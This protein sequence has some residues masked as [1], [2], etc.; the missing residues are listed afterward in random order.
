MNWMA[1]IPEPPE[2]GFQ[3]QTPLY[4]LPPYS[5]GYWCLV[6]TWEFDMAVNW[7]E[8]FQD[9][10]YGHHMRMDKIGE[11]PEY[12]DGHVQPCDRELMGDGTPYF[13]AT[14]GGLVTGLMNLDDD[15]GVVVKG[16]DRWLIQ[17]HFYNTTDQEIW[18]QDTVNIGWIEL[19]GLEKPLS[20]WTFDE[21]EFELPPQQVSEVEFTCTWPQDV[22]VVMWMVHMHDRALSFTSEVQQEDLSWE[23]WYD[24]EEWDPAWYRNPQLEMPAEPVFF[25]EGQSLKGTCRINNDTESTRVWPDEMCVLEGLAYP[26]YDGI[27]S[28]YVC[29]SDH[30][31][32]EDPVP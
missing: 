5:E 32:A 4:K 12:P 31:N 30:P 7:F 10:V 15:M 25:P 28:R 22:Y 2:G 29:D 27:T 3:I 19:E 18:V 26:L 1:Y 14:E 21:V 16:G 20:T 6:G 17:S 9:P 24:I 8:W 13:N 23:P 11:M